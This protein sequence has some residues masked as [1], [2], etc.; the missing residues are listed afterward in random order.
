MRIYEIGTGYTSIPAR[1]G[2]ATEIIVEKLTKEFMKEGISVELFDIA[3]AR[4]LTNELP[5]VEVKVPLIF[6]STDT[7]L[8]IMHKL[9]RVVYSIALAKE[10]RKK[11]KSSKEEL[12]LHFHNQYNMFFFLMFISKKQR[13]KVK[14][15]Y[16]VHSGIWS[17]PWNEIKDVIKKRY[18][19][20]I[21]CIQNADKVFVL[22]GKIRENFIENL[23]VK[24]ENLCQ[25]ANGADT[26]AYFLMKKDEIEQ[27]KGTIGLEGK[28][29]VLQV[30]SI[31][32][33]KNQLEALETLCRYLRENRSVVYMYAGGII[34]NSYKERI[35]N[36]ARE[37]EIESQV[38]YVGEISPGEQLNQ[39]YNAAN[40]T[41]FPSKVEAFS[42]TII[43]SLCAGTPV[44]IC[45]KLIFELSQN[46]LIFHNSDE[47]L[48]MVKENIEEENREE[49]NYMNVRCQYSWN[50][51]AKDYI[52][53]IVGENDG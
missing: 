27:F 45:D 50:N 26:D 6:R 17:L 1:V 41:V 34:D 51:I 4:R 29:I 36:F 39:Y 11:I 3:D 12:I 21:Y 32:E 14:L 28:S 33:N 16:T 47:F 24:K 5:I 25:I 42:L 9:K 44:I 19:Q 46:C 38:I 53:K 15:I 37:N 40:I 13:K 7:Q 22:N 8:G 20:E 31:C 35:D 18:F 30:G 52:S 2:A 10:L 49:K 48:R 43:E 23:G